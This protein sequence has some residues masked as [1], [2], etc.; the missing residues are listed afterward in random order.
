MGVIDETLLPI[1]K[2]MN[3]KNTWLY[4]KAVCMCSDNRY[5]NYAVKGIYLKL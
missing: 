2:S 5:Y 3:N 4:K 1:L